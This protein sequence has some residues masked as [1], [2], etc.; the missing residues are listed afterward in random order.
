[1]HVVHMSEVGTHVGM[2]RSFYLVLILFGKWCW[3]SPIPNP[4]PRPRPRPNPRPCP[5]ALDLTL[6]Q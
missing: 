3:P 4:S 5:S 1:M 6:A 2:Y